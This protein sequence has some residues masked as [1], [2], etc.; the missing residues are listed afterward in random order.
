MA[1]SLYK[2]KTLQLIK[3][4]CGCSDMSPAEVRRIYS[5]TNSVHESLL[6]PQATRLF[7]KFL[8]MKRSGD[9]T[10]AEQYLDI[11][12]KCAE[13]LLETQ[14]TFTQDEVDELVDLDLPYD[15]EQ[16]LS[17]RMLSGNRT[18]INSGLYRIQ[19]KCRNEIEASS[20]FADFR[21]AIVDKM[22]RVPK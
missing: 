12:E 17:R 1:A 20:D 8:E 4:F 2:D 21:N 22:R 11:Y 14:R 3:C 9:K 7:R 16:D 15:L 5:L 19:G 18:D 10:A 6:D 13:F